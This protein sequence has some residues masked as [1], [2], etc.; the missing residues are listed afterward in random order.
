MEHFIDVLI[1]VSNICVK[2]LGTGHLAS[3]IEKMQTAKRFAQQFPPL[4]FI[5][6]PLCDNKRSGTNLII[7]E[8]KGGYRNNNASRILLS[9]NGNNKTKWASDL[10]TDSEIAQGR[11]GRVKNNNA[12]KG[13]EVYWQVAANDE[14]MES[15]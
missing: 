15:R 14:T 7:Q 11:A 3:A 13:R 6:E 5:I 2:S 12:K 8:E 4:F 1:T 10:R 9:N